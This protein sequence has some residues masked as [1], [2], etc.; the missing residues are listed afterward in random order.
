MVDIVKNVTFFWWSFSVD[1]NQPVQND[2]TDPSLYIE[3]NLSPD[4]KTIINE[5]RDYTNAHPTDY[6]R[7][8]TEVVFPT[9]LN[10]EMVYQRIVPRIL[11][12]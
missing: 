5:S 3:S 6:R 4:I 12:E 2:R 1:F 9:L 10:D 11:S 8:H 7:D